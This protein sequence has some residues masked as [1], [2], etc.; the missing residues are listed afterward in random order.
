MY[1]TKCDTDYL[2][3]GKTFAKSAKNGFWFLFKKS[4]KKKK[5]KAIHVCIIPHCQ[6]GS[7]FVYKPNSNHPTV[8]QT[9]KCTTY[10]AYPLLS[11]T[12]QKKIKCLPFWEP[13]KIH[14]FP[15]LC[16]RKAFLTLESW[17]QFGES[18]RNRNKERERERERERGKERERQ[19]KSERQREKQTERQ[20]ERDRQRK[21]NGGNYYELC[22]KTDIV[23]E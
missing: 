5:I 4:A 1:S 23:A 12:R 8:F 18:G 15:A 14:S 6:V 13:K 17:E 3:H 21:L 19:R 10:I 20:T 2:E 7:T 11:R 22:Q 9:S 16:L